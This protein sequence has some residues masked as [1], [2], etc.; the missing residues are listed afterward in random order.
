M[1][2]VSKQ[3]GV[4]CYLEP[5]EAFRAVLGEYRPGMIIFNHMQ[6]SHMTRWSRRLADIGVLTAVHLN[7]GILYNEAHRR[8]MAGQHHSDGH[9]DYYFCWNEAHKDALRKEKVGQ[10]SEIAVTGVPRF[11]FYF[12]PWSR[13]TPAVPKKKG[14]ASATF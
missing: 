12:E 2:G 9:I 3:A 1:L 13:L 6:G 10:S 14:R 11:D 8:F 7:E 4:E 5:L